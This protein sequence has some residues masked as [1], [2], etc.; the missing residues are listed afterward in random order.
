[1]NTEK[2]KAIEAAYGEQYENYK[3]AINE[4]GWTEIDEEKLGFNW[5]EENVEYFNFD[6]SNLWRPKALSGIENN[7][8]WVK[9]ESEKDLPKETQYLWVIG[10]QE[11]MGRFELILFQGDF[12]TPIHKTC[13]YYK[14]IEKPLL[15][16][17]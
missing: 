6:T 17:Y 16:I 11:K 3:S 15:P 12:F 10:K 5:L 1:M 7:R 14:V 8:G 9:I 13:T 4:N 2:Q